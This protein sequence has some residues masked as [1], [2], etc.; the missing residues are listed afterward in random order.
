MVIEPGIL[1]PTF[2]ILYTIMFYKAYQITKKSKTA[3]KRNKAAENQLK[4]EMKLAI[5]GAILS[6]IYVEMCVSYV[7]YALNWTALWI[8][9][10]SYYGS[11]LFAACNPYLLIIFSPRLRG[12][13]VEF[14]TCGKVSHQ[15]IHPTT[16]RCRIKE[17]PPRIRPAK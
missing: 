6:T 11:D 8:V 17:K 13:F 7:L 3:A 14:C 9:C 12:Y 10:M 2:I 15:K 1:A 16:N 5:M 4:M